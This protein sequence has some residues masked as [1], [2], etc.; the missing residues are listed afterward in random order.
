[1]IRQ[2]ILLFASGAVLFGQGPLDSAAFSFQAQQEVREDTDYKSGRSALDAGQWDQAIAFFDASIAHHSAVAD[3]ALYWKA[4]AQNRA[5]HRDQA[6]STIAQLRKSYPSS[7]WVND[8]QALEVEIRG[9]S[10]DP[11]NPNAE[12]NEELKVIALNSLMQSD[13]NQAFPILAEDPSEQQFIQGEREG[14]LH[15]DPELIGS[16][17]EAA[18]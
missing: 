11:V 7:R 8:A 1:M 13:P 10:G 9:N 4:Y 18:N 2:M 14:T 3:G 5:G 16:V 12:S 17:S 6:L 15:P